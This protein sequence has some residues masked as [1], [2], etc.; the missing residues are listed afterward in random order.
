MPRRGQ[1][2]CMSVNVAVAVAL[3]LSS[4]LLAEWLTLS[5]LILPH[6]DDWRGRVEKLAAQAIGLKLSPGSI[7]VQCSGWGPALERRD[8]RLLIAPNFDAAVSAL[9]TMA[10]NLAM[11]RWA[12]CLHNGCCSSR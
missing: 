7:R 4:V 6:I 12:A 9:T 8:L 10:S 11:G 5:Q 3:L 2:L 1:C